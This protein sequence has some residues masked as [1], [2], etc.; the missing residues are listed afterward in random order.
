[1]KLKKMINGGDA[2]PE[3][4][5]G[6]RIDYNFCNGC[7]ECYENCPMDVFGWDKEKRQPTLAHPAEC[8]ICCVCEVVCPEVAI[9]VSIPLHV[10]IDFGLD[11]EKKR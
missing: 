1:M 6:P 10:R 9:D 11:P 4:S 2:M 7:G 8:R 5:Y 3:I